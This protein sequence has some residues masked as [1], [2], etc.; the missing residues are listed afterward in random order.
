MHFRICLHHFH[1]KNCI[2]L[3]PSCNRDGNQFFFFFTLCVVRWGCIDPAYAFASFFFFLWF[4]KPAVSCCPTVTFA[5]LLLSCRIKTVEGSEKHLGEVK[6]LPCFSDLG[7]KKYFHS[8]NKSPSVF[9]GWRKG[10]RF[11][12]LGPRFGRRAW[13][14]R[15]AVPAGPGVAARRAHQPDRQP[16]PPE[17]LRGRRPG[18]E[19]GA[20]QRHLR[21]HLACPAHELSR[22][23]RHPPQ[24][25][26][27]A[28]AGGVLWQVSGWNPSCLLRRRGLLLLSTFLVGGERESEAGEDGSSEEKLL[29]KYLLEGFKDETFWWRIWKILFLSNYFSDER[30]IY[31]E[32]N[33]AGNHLMSYHQFFSFFF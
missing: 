26:T 22:Q 23:R 19:A 12:R 27:Q 24:S 20:G 1:P 9:S 16:L 5:A 29:S 17:A 28:A 11:A 6:Y 7:R 2:F 15:G 33:V 31:F 18:G 4:W 25:A 30:W 13:R 8:N 10:G 21:L 3:K 32:V 14:Q